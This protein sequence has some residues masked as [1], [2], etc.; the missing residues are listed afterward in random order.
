[1]S[2]DMLEKA[3][4]ERRHAQESLKAFYLEAGDRELAGDELEK[5]QRLSDAITTAQER[6]MRLFEQIK[7][8]KDID[9]ARAEMGPLPAPVGRDQSVDTPKV[10]EHRAL[11]AFL[12]GETPG[13]AARG[14]AFDIGFETRDDI[15]LQKADTDGEELVPQTM[16]SSIWDL[17][18]HESMLLQAGPTI[19]R[20]SGGEKITVPH[21]TS[22]SAAALVAEGD[23]IGNNSPQFDHA[24]L[25]AYKYAF[26]IPVTYEL[27]AD[28]SFDVAGFV[29]GHG[30]AALGR[31]INTAFVTGSGSSQPQGVDLAT[32]GKQIA[33]TIAPTDDELIDLVHS[34]SPPSRAN[35]AW[36]L[37][38][39]VIASIRKID[40]A[41]NNVWQPSLRAGQPD[42]LLGAPVYADPNLAGTGSD[43]IIGVYGDL[44]G[45]YVRQAGGFRIERSDDYAFNTDHATFKFVARVDSAIVDTVGIRTMQD[46]T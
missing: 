35:A 13:N 20:T 15:D 21:V 36:L 14:N 32:V 43:N 37:N 9:E 46:P 6:E 1:M 17:V 25:D 11:N 38:D 26:L 29:R 12:R 3:F 18:V 23:A 2:V 42:M 31:G 45:F 8:D 7:R 30:A 5:E 10:S 4:A 41:T 33:T 28:S 39:T 19:I 22:N 27:L 16:Y 40:T 34:V 44:R 24:E